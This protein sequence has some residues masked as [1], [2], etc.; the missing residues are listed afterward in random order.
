MF[1][2]SPDTG[3]LKEIKNTSG[4][5]LQK[6]QNLLQPVLLSKTSGDPERAGLTEAF[7]TRAEVGGREACTDKI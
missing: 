5:N 4:K 1:E 6:K 3:P 7:A 2:V